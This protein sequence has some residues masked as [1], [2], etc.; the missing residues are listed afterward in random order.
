MDSARRR[1]GARL[2]AARER[3]SRDARPLSGSGRALGGTDPGSTSSRPTSS[4]GAAREPRAEGARRA[5]CCC[6]CCGS[7]FSC[8]GGAFWP[9]AFLPPAFLPPFLP[10]CCDTSAAASSSSSSS[11]SSASF[12]FS[13][14][15]RCA[16]AGAG[17]GP[18]TKRSNL[19]PS[20]AL[21]SARAGE[22]RCAVGTWWLHGGHVV[23]AWRWLHGVCM[24]GYVAAVTC[25]A[26]LRC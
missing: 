14:A 16:T 2:S 21:L 26:A 15:A 10:P 8:G 12:R 1:A 7:A 20:E 23:V 11:S 4:G 9:P 17:A 5:G 3:R 19:L 18:A 25:E 22:A 6:G 24:G 13:R